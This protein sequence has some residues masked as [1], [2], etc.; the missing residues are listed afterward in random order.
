MELTECNTK[1]IN[2]LRITGYVNLVN[3]YY[4][5]FCYRLENY[6]PATN[7]LWRVALQW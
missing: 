3:K 7:K 5:T 4:K 2:L 6:I 1:K